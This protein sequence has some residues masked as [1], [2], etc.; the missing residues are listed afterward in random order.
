MFSS[1]SFQ[2]IN[3]H[4]HIFRSEITQEG[5]VTIRTA[6]MISYIVTN[7]KIV[8]TVSISELCSVSE[9]CLGGVLCK[10]LIETYL[11]IISFS[12]QDKL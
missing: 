5:H 7:V 12:V 9:L 1:V 6:D 3:K 11:T 8:L 2:V 10:N 4:L